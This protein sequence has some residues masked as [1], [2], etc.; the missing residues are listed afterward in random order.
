MALSLTTR[1][2]AGHDYYPPQPA[3]FTWLLAP[4]PPLLPTRHVINYRSPKFYFLV[5]F[6]ES[7][8]KKCTLY[9]ILCHINNALLF[10]LHS[11]RMQLNILSWPVCPPALFSLL[12]FLLLRPLLT[13]YGTEP[14]PKI[15]TRRVHQHGC[16]P[17]CHFQYWYCPSS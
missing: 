3:S 16:R 1:W 13:N 11:I 2:L 4:H 12:S 17:V 14:V 6:R 7:E 5:S 8:K 10:P 9:F 15:A